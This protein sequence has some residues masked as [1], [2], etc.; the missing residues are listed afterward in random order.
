[1]IWMTWGRTPITIPSL[2]CSA[3]GALETFLRFVN[4]KLIVQFTLTRLR[5]EIICFVDNYKLTC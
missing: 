4:G 5:C 3:I 1:M 2:R